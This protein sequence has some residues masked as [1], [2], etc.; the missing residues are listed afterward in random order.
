MSKAEGER[1][2]RVIY[3]HLWSNTHTH[4]AL[5]IVTSA[6]QDT[7]SLHI[8]KGGVQWTKRV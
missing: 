8:A 3:T 4:D 7:H 5:S 2:Q 1:R 6:H